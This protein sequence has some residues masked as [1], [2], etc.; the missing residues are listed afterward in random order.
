MKINTKFNANNL[1][2]CLPI[3]TEKNQQP[4]FL[5]HNSCNIVPERMIMWKTIFIWPLISRRP[6]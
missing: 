2:V 3:Q 5:E 1:N 6:N 4:E